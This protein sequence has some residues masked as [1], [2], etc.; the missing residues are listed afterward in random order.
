MKNI[1][2]HALLVL[3]ST[4][5]FNSSV[6][7]GDKEP[8]LTQEPTQQILPRGCVY[9]KPDDKISWSRNKKLESEIQYFSIEIYLGIPPGTPESDIFNCNFIITQWLKDEWTQTNK[10]KL[11]KEKLKELFKLNVKFIEEIV[12][13]KKNYTLLEL[14]CLEDFYKPAVLALLFPD[15]AEELKDVKIKQ[16]DFCMSIKS[17][18]TQYSYC[19]SFSNCLPQEI[20]DQ[21]AK[22][23]VAKFNK[24]TPHEQIIILDSWLANEWFYELNG[25]TIKIEEDLEN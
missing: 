10:E 3:I 4:I 23:I 14:C 24:L 17:K 11:D 7:A 21:V 19:C 12:K 16:R 1:K 18:K 13:Y 25:E 6:F 2:K 5:I 22:D 8:V 15:M 9:V 20:I